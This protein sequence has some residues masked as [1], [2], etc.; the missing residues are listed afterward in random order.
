MAD[1][2]WCVVASLCV[3]RLWILSSSQEQNQNVTMGY[4]SLVI[5]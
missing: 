4:I 5:C 3:T 2:Y 1:V